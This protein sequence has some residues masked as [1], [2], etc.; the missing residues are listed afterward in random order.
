MRNIADGEELTVDYAT[1]L[2]ESLEPFACQCGAENCREV[3]V[4]NKDNAI[5]SVRRGAKA[6][7]FRRQDIL[8]P[9]LRQVWGGQPKA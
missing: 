4:G 3:V 5:N 7:T 2:D 9:V 8:V 6:P 1:F